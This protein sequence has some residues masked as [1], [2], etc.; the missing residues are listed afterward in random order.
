MGK[1]VK[2]LK[3]HSHEDFADFLVKTVL[4]LLVANV[5]HA[6]HCV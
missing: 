3:G 6:Q 2:S 5:I 1:G 4:K